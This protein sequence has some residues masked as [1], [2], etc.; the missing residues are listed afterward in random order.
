MAAPTL[1]NT[2]TVIDACDS[3]TSWSVA[4]TYD[5]DIKKQ[6]QNSASVCLRSSTAWMRTGLTLNLTGAHLA[7][8]LQTSCLSY[9]VDTG[10]CIQAAVT[11]GGTTYYWTVRKKPGGAESVPEYSGGWT[12]I[13]VDL[14]RNHDG[15]A[16]ATLTSVTAVGIRM[17]FGATLPRNNIINTWID[18]IYYIP[19][20]AVGYKIAGGTSGDKVTWTT[21]ATADA[22]AGWGIVVSDAGVYRVNAPIAFGDD[23]GTNPCYFSGANEIIVTGSGP[24]NTAFYKLNGIGN[25]T[26]A[27]D[28][29]FTGS[30]FKAS[31]NAFSFDMS[32]AAVDAVTIDGCT[33]QG[34]G[35]ITFKTGQS[36]S[37]SVFRSCGA[38]TSGGATMTGC[39]FASSTNEDALIIANVTQMNAVTNCTFNSNTHGVRL[40]ATGDYTFTGHQFS[41]NTADVHS[42]GLATTNITPT[43]SNVSTKFPNDANT[44]I[45]NNKVLQLTGLVVGSDI[46]IL[47]AGTS[48]ERVNVDGNNATTYNYTYAYVA[49][50][51]VDI[52]VF[53]QGYI[54]YAIRNYLLPSG[55][56][57]VPI[58]QAVDRNFNNPS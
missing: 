21:V 20:G 16:A 4:P 30:T 43:N 1:L 39:T 54:P 11:A 23:A 32:P 58:S 36:I 15:G 48:T 28:L 8:W 53:K 3:G 38:V 50:T 40:N 24:V 19:S 25:A 7:F 5:P 9:L 47:N 41:G 27:T 2:P 44:V 51:Y 14:S 18:N 49:G 33:F 13:V 29:T 34:G 22:T 46:V 26:G 57:S 56:G 52:C 17:Q 37:N 31:G 35:A 42:T 45:N 6:G 55:G 10:Q 12:L